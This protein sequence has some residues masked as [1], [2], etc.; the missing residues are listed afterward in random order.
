MTKYLIEERALLNSFDIPV[1]LILFKR[2][3][4]VLRILER[5]SQVRPSKIYLLSD[6]GRNDTEKELVAEVRKTVE[7]YIF[8]DCEIIKN[9]ASENRGVYANIALGA[10]WVFER[11]EMAIFLEDDNLPEVSFFAYCK[12]LLE[13]YKND[14]R[15]FW[16]CG[17]NYLGKYEPENG[18]SYMYT[19]HLL[20]CGWASWRDKFNAYYDYDLDL[21]SSQQLKRRVKY[22]YEDK[23]LYNQQIAN[24]AKEK[25]KANNDERYISWDY[26]M[27]WSIRVNNV[28]GISP[29]YNQIKNIGVD[30]FSE[31]GGNSLEKEMTRRFCGMDSYSLDLPLKHPDTLLTDLEYENKIG[32]LILQPLSNRIRSNVRIIIGNVFKLSPEISISKMIK[33]KIIRRK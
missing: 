30:N 29:K 1:V 9:Y 20:P 24:V 31:H 13:K 22:E 2:R 18:C 6:E 16:V 23:R 27:A 17:T 15:V 12:E 33:L 21:F 10:K 8:W 11:E 28:Y 14:S 19:K 7:N 32:E 5:V 3:D 26:H 4:T 25:Y